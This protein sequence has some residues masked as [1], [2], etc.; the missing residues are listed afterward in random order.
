MVYTYGTEDPV[1]P[2]NIDKE[3]SKG[4][5]SVLLLSK[6][7]IRNIDKTGWTSFAMTANVRI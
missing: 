2:M 3:V 4:S 5:R 7:D 1:S 6:R